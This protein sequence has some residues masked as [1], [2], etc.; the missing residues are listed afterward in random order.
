[1]LSIGQRALG[2][3]SDEQI[4]Q[5]KRGDVEKDVDFMGLIVFR[6]ELKEDTRDAIIEMKVSPHK[7]GYVLT[8]RRDVVQGCLS[9]YRNALMA[10]AFG[11]QK[12]AV[13]PVMIT[14]DNAQCGYYIARSASLLDEGVGILLGEMDRTS[15][16][17]MW[18]QMGQD[19]ESDKPITTD[20]VYN[21][22]AVRDGTLELAITGNDAYTELYEMI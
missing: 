12:G 11:L 20:E 2:K 6:N 7:W 4:G 19:H 22:S 18:K 5:L 10:D 14:G 17:V 13:R 1:M 15:K 21:H 16:R 8:M 3:L 9:S